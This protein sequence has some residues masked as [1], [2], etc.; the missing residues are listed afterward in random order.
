MKLV[1]FCCS[2]CG[3]PARSASVVTT[4]K[5]PVVFCYDSRRDVETADYYLDFDRPLDTF[6]GTRRSIGPETIELECRGG[7][8][9]QTEV[10]ADSDDL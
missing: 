8:I 3:E 6:Y 5:V 4:V 1:K 10:V 7:H 2:E 9:W